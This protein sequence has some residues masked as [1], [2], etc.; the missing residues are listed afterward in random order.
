MICIPWQET[1]QLLHGEKNEGLILCELLVKQKHAI[2]KVISQRRNGSQLRL[3]ASF[4]ATHSVRKRPKNGKNPQ[5]RAFPEIKIFFQRRKIGLGQSEDKFVSQPDGTV[6]SD[7]N[8]QFSDPEND[9]KRVFCEYKHVGCHFLRIFH[10]ESNTTSPKS[11]KC[12]V[13][14]ET[15]IFQNLGVQK[16]VKNAF[17]VNIGMWI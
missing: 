5:V 17:F 14:P 13:Q 11:P 9:Q 7:P 15:V 10:A 8:V 12:T 2:L 16:V 6:S 3:H 1:F 4:A